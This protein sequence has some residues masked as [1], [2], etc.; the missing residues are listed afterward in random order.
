MDLISSH[1]ILHLHLNTFFNLI[2]V[3]FPVLLGIGGISQI[4]KFPSTEWG[5]PDYESIEEDLFFIIEPAVELEFNMARF[6][7]KKN[8]IKD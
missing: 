6:F 2:H 7:R 4:A 8:E 5:Y 3:T 1:T